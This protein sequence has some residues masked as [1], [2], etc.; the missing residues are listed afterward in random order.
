MAQSS[1]AASRSSKP[2]AKPKRYCRIKRQQKAGPQHGTANLSHTQHGMLKLIANTPE[3]SITLRAL[4]GS[5]GGN[6]IATVRTLSELRRRDEVSIAVSKIDRLKGLYH[7]KLKGNTAPDAGRAVLK[8]LKV[9]EK[10][11]KAVPEEARFAT[12]PVRLTDA[13]Q[14]RVLRL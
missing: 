12:A 6:V 10:S 9:L 2:K 5:C 8:L 7:K 4:V 14:A 3:H 11:E 1:A 13:G